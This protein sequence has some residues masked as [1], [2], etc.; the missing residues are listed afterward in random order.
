MLQKL[1]DEDDRIRKAVEDAETKR[2]KEE[3][4]KEAKTKKAFEE[5]AK[6]RHQM[7]RKYKQTVFSKS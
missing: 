7:V 2:E 1:D 6:H 4:E 5:M 3:R